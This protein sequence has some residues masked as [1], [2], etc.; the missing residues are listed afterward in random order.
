M[1]PVSPVPSAHSQLMAYKLGVH[2][3]SGGGGGAGMHNGFFGPG[4]HGGAAVGNG[5]GGGSGSSVGGLLGGV[6]G[7]MMGPNGALD[8]VSGDYIDLNELLNMDANGCHDEVVA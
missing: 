5:N 1:S 2:N 4:I 8:I 6:N 3:G 7:M